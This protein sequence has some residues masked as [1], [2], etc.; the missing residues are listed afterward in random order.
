MGYM[1]RYNPAVVL[2]RNFLKRGWLG[3]P[4][5]VHAV[6]SKVVAPASRSGL[7]EYPG[8]IMFE[9]GCHITDLVIGVLGAPATSRPFK[10]HVGTDRRRSGRQHAG[11]V[12]ISRG[13]SPL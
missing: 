2:L 1:Y 11:R 13:Q 7:A 12:G 3:E 9:L 4:F 5:E 6:M 10:Q 8:G